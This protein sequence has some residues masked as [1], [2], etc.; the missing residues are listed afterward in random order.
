MYN[1]IINGAP[2]V[3]GDVIVVGSFSVTI[4]LP[5]CN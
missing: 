1:L 3:N 2:H 5:A 4:L